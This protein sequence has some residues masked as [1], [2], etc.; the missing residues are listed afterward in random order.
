MNCSATAYCT[1]VPCPYCLKLLLAAGIVRVVCATGYGDMATIE[2][3]CAQVG[4]PL[5]VYGG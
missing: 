5:E 3:L 1:H 2:E 4:V